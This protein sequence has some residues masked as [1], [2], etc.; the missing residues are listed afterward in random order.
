MNGSVTVCTYSG[1]PGPVIVRF[2]S[3]EDPST[4][5][6]GKQSFAQNGETT[7]DVAGIGDGAYSSTSGS[8]QAQTNTLVVLKGTIELLVTAPVTLDDVSALVRQILP[9][10]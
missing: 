9:S 2:Q 7:D 4:F 8:G 1:T 3:G 10:I 5:A 6:A